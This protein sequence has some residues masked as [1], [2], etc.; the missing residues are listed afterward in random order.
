MKKKNHSTLSFLKKNV[1]SD[2]LTVNRLFVSSF[3]GINNLTKP[4][5]TLLSQYIIYKDDVD[6]ELL[7]IVQEHIR[8]EYG[9]RM[10][11][12]TV[13]KLFE[14]VVSPAD[15]IVTGAVYTPQNVRKTILHQCLNNQTIEKINNIRIAD[16]SCG[17]GGFLIDVALWIHE[18]TGK[19]FESIIRENIYGID[20]QEYAIERTKIL[21]SL[22][23]L[24]YGEDVNL[25]FNLLCRDTL[26]YTNKD[27]DTSFGNFDVI[28]GNP[29]YVCSR[30][31]STETY[32]KMRNYVVCSSGHPDLYIPFFQIA[33]E[34]L[35]NDGR[36]GFITMNTFIRSVNGRALRSY[37]SHNMF[38]IK[39][40]DFRGFQVFESK[41]TYTCL[42]YL[43]K[44]KESS[45]IDYAV[46]ECGLLS[47]DVQ[48]DAIKYTDLDNKKGWTLN[49][50]NETIEIES[51]GIQIKDFCPSRH[52][53]ATLSNKTYIFSPTKENDK[54][55]YLSNKE[56]VFP[57]EKEICRNIINPNKL[58]SINDFKVLLEKVIFP[59]YLEDGHAIIYTP[60]EMSCRF[61][62]ALF[63]LRTRK[64]ILLK[65]DKDGTSS[66]PQW[67][68]YGRTQSLNLPKY[69]LFFPKFANK[70]LRC[71]MSDDPS[72]MLYNGLAFVNNDER[73]LKILKAI[74][75]SE[76]FW[77]YIQT[78]GK[79][80]AS[81]YYSLSGVDIKHFSI[82]N[83]T[84]E[85]ENELLSFNN[86]NKIE[87]WL[88]VHYK[89]KHN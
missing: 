89:K 80:Y 22:L 5:S 19:S 88:R 81:G 54:Y 4:K 18:R 51:M 3:I 17:C 42:F 20:I 21:L 61:P 50:F 43:D 1:P 10:T 39:I 62:M 8:T 82:P 26:D 40:V 30:N 65:R 55:Y 45:S 73:K 85:E 49:K 29:P 56:G 79:P 76:L 31:L 34:M 2:E 9:E 75:E 68:A 12:E 53:I 44:L 71:I 60:N 77:N 36:L 47:T 41:N 13:V 69:K 87:K 57:I 11:L 70:P 48:Y 83:F 66:Y 28:M 86:Y 16:I 52:G 84:I 7:Q 72:L 37:F 46:D 24:L 25:I 67:Y 78:N 35:N 38:K 58:N 6:Y 59:Y 64:E 74:I 15:R 27:W 14:F 63:Y 23:S 33:I 32:K